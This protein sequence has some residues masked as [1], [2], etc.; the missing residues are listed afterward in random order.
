[1]MPQPLSVMCAENPNP[2]RESQDLTPHCLDVLEQQE[3]VLQ[4]DAFGSR[5]ALEVG[6]RIAELARSYDRGVSAAIIREQDGLTLF[7]FAM[8]DKSPRNDTF[9]L[10][11]RKAALESGHSSLWAYVKHALTGEYEELFARMPETL[12]FAGAFP[13]RVHGEWT[14]TLTISGLHDGKDHELAIL[15]L[16]QVLKREVPAFPATAV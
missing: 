1:M 8:D 11:K 10:G 5:E 6:N 3:A 15:A 2:V 13:I 16:S 9:M 4:F 12:P 7:Q 14:A